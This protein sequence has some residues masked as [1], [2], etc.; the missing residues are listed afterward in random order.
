MPSH[1]RGPTKTSAI[2]ASPSTTRTVRSALPSLH[3]MVTSIRFRVQLTWLGS[4][5]ARAPAQS[6]LQRVRVRAEAAE[7]HRRQCSLTQLLRA[8]CAGAQ[9]L[10]DSHA[11]NARCIG[12]L[13]DRMRRPRGG[14]LA[15]GADVDTGAIAHSRVRASLR[16]RPRRQSRANP[17]AVTYA[18]TR[19]TTTAKVVDSARL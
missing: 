5:A 4:R 18:P 15:R 8:R 1:V 3:V 19:M 12:L 14:R 17:V 7:R 6:S 10:R 16:F 9:K 2:S 11:Q 13:R